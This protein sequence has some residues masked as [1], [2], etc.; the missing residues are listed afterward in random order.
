MVAGSKPKAKGG[1]SNG[2][3]STGRGASEKPGGNASASGK[4]LATKQKSISSFF[5]GSSGEASA[6]VGSKPKQRSIASFFGGN[7]GAK[8]PALSPKA[9]AK[10]GAG[11]LG[12]SR[13]S[14]GAGNPAADTALPSPQEPSSV[15]H[16]TAAAVTGSPPSNK[17]GGAVDA[18]PSL[19]GKK[20]GGVCNNQDGSRE[21]KQGAAPH[22]GGGGEGSAAGE[23]GD[24]EST[25][26]VA[27]KERD[28]AL[29]D[30]ASQKDHAAGRKRQSNADDKDKDSAEVPVP[31]GKLQREG[32]EDKV[33]DKESLSTKSAVGRRRKRVVGLVGEGEE[34]RRDGSDGTTLA[35]GEPMDMTPDGDVG[36][37][38]HHTVNDNA[39]TTPIGERNEKPPSP[40]GTT[41]AQK[42]RRRLRKVGDM[43]NGSSENNSALRRHELTDDADVRDD[44]K[45]RAV[46]GDEGGVQIRTSPDESSEGDAAVQQ[47]AAAHRSPKLHA[48]SDVRSFFLRGAG[49]LGGQGACINAKDDAL[50]AKE[51]TGKE[52]RCGGAS[53]HGKETR[54]GAANAEEKEGDASKGKGDSKVK[55]RGTGRSEAEGG[56]RE[57]KSGRGGGESEQPEEKR[58]AASDNDDTKVQ[59]EV[60]DK[61]AAT[62]GKVSANR[63][64]SD[65][66]KGKQK[67]GGGQTKGKLGASAS[68]AGNGSA[69]CQEPKTVTWQ[70]GER[71][72]YLFLAEALHRVSK[73]SSRLAMTEIMCNVFRTVMQT[74]PEDLLPVV[75]LSV[76]KVASPH[77]GIEL[78]IGEATLT[79]ALA[80]ATGRKESQ[81]KHECKETGDLGL[82]AQ[83]SRTTQRTMF[84]PQ[85]LTCV[86]VL[87]AFLFIAK[88][89]GPSSQD[90]KRGRIKSLLV[91]ARDCEPQ[92]IIRSLQGKMRIGLAEQTVL[93]ALAQAA[94]LE[95]KPPFPQSELAAKLDEAVK[96]I[97]KVHSEL[98]CYDKIV[99]TILDGGIM[100][101]PEVCHFTLGVPVGPML[102]KPT[103]GVSEILDKFQEIIFTSEYKYDGERAQIHCME[104]GTIEIYSRNAERNTGKFPDLVTSMKK[105]TK[106]ETKSYVI[107]CEAVGYD[108]ETHKILPF[109]IL[110]TRARKGV[111]MG[112][113]KVQVCLFA[114]DILYYNG[115]PLLREQ[116]KTR[117][118]VLYDAFTEVK[119]E[120]Q[121]A[122]ALNS[123][124]IEEIQTFLQDAVNSSCE[125]LIVKTLDTDATYEPAKRSNNWLKLKKD[126]MD[127]IG[128]SVDLVPIGAFYGR[129][130]RA[131]VYGAF[132]LA[133]YD[134]DNEEYQSICK[135]GT[136]FSEAML[137]ERSTALKEKVVPKPRPYYRYGESLGA[138]VWFDPCEVWEV[139]AAD[140]SIS[141]VH[142]AAVGHVDQ[143]KG[144][145]LRFPRFLRV[146]TDKQP[147]E[148]TTA[149][150]IAE[151][152]RSQANR[153]HENG[154]GRQDD[155]E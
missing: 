6:A 50:S 20:A 136:G 121:F 130:K 11:E 155:D 35:A 1:S 33:E 137:E 104:D 45:A 47:S 25:K 93:V 111:I 3:T 83:H 19:K 36:E 27:R 66:G 80:E 133:C 103:N 100:R 14:E 63:V 40:D 37:A 149:A 18:S 69:T 97:K 74:T 5:G 153:Q 143:S 79:K 46:S 21:D 13:G 29:K 127:N 87:E 59:G 114:F 76:N 128:D 131:G 92:F 110:S 85:P 152:Y 142:R 26:R 126:Y 132:L 51:R 12:E 116:L 95:H 10:S 65:G 24:K 15:E 60:E 88:E 129:G 105:Y 38:G 22:A 135:I 124:D 72:P 2:G 106:P 148:A 75:Y 84:A 53:S 31:A 125:G 68:A 140:L 102:A 90:K 39:A 134:D 119:G 32:D 117:R 96:I 70:P 41:S 138:D 54:V 109:Q 82:V 107:D 113:I 77:E 44:A 147:E 49:K 78:G 151:L 122:T 55:G 4:P 56:K 86:K 81:I 43:T 42:K 101:L 118:E 17:G 154:P 28:L 123:R 99:P 58:D 7:S 89:T 108:R 145:A 139:K 146:R 23:D 115:K 98:P 16:P 112:D 120:F 52:G 91:S 64:P 71:V 8:S 67:K 34:E 141:P 48:G 30:S 150:Q 94:V 9:A 62:G 57:S 144:I 61:D 73:E